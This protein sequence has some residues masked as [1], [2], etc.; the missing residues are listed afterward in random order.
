[1]TWPEGAPLNALFAKRESDGKDWYEHVNDPASFQQ[2]TVKIA[3]LFHQFEQEWII[4]P[5]TTDATMIFPANMHVREID[6]FGSI[7]EEEII[8]A[9]RNKVINLKTHAM[10]RPAP[11][12]KG[13]PSLN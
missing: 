4:G 6:G 8:A 13:R 5:A 9:F 12:L 1:M 3:I 2:D 7:D 11:N 10:E